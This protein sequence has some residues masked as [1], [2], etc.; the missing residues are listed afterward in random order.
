LLHRSRS[1]GNIHANRG[2]V[3]AFSVPSNLNELIGFKDDKGRRR[4]G[5][6][7]TVFRRSTLS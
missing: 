2:F 6:L 5:Y 3:R 4:I 1:V 7:D